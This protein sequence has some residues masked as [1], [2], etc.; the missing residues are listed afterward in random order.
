MSDLTTFMFHDVRDDDEYPKR[1]NLKSFLTKNHFKDMVIQINQ[2]YTIVNSNYIGEIDFSNGNT[3][4]AILT[5]DDGLKD[6]YWV[7]KYLKSAGLSASFFV[8]KM[9]ILE[10]KVMDT[11]KIQFILACAEEREVVKYILSFFSNVERNE[12]WEK[13]SKTQWKDNWWSKEMIFTTNFLRKFNGCSPSRIDIIECLW[14]EYV[15]RDESQFSESFY[16]DEREIDEMANNNMIIGGH[17][18]ISEN[19]EFMSTKEYE[20]ELKE[21]AK[22]ISKWTSDLTMSY[23]NGGL[24]EH[25]VESVKKNGFIKAF[26]TVKKTITDLDKI[27]YLELPRYDAPRDVKL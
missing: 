1:Y 24:N 25:I 8:P 6:H 23:P 26:T 2:R 5:F 10:H 12:I 17:G 19:M 7:Y 13:Y 27:D 16:L 22:F 21:A 11:H 4:Y 20:N 3:K 15:K 18:D 14:K 9:P